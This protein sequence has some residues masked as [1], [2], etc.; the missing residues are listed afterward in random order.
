MGFHTWAML[1]LVTGL[2]AKFFMPVD[3]HGG[4]L[5]TICLGVG[6]AVAGGFV[7]ILAFGLGDQPRLDL[8]VPL[9]A[10]GGAILVLVGYGLSNRHG[11]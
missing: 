10:V 7:G 9:T 3:R 2:L 1:G 11:A 5:I 6:G 4:L 8:R